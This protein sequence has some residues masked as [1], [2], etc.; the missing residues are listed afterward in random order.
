MWIGSI[1]Q[2]RPGCVL[3]MGS[4]VPNGEPVIHCQAQ[5]Q[6]PNHDLCSSTPLSG[7]EQHRPTRWSRTAKVTPS[8]SYRVAIVLSLAAAVITGCEG[9]TYRPV[10][11][12]HQELELNEL[13][14]VPIEHRVIA[15]AD[16]SEDTG[17]L[18]WT[19]S[20]VYL[21]RAGTHPG[22][23]LCQG[24]L[25]GVAAA[26][27][28]PGTSLVEIVDSTRQALF[29]IRDDGSCV[30]QHMRH[31]GRRIAGAAQ[32]D[33]SWTILLASRDQPVQLE[34]LRFGGRPVL[35]V[36]FDALF[37]RAYNVSHLVLARG[38]GGI[39]LSSAQWPFGWMR[40][41]SA[42]ARRA[43]ATGALSFGTQAYAE[44]FRSWDALPA[45]ALDRAVA[46]TLVDPAS[47]RRLLVVYDTLGRFMSMTQ[48]GSSIEVRAAARH[49]SLLVATRSGIGLELVVY[50]WKWTP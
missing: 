27:F 32:S 10:V 17:L 44:T 40:L 41:D 42:G 49:A 5:R 18:Y 19:L 38:R 12:R 7:Q 25:E 29:H 33:G 2:L 46:Q 16:V 11:P 4:L 23:A 8:Q 9:P 35:A 6:D 20:A 36:T 24:R 1:P 39:L 13:L 26:S 45:V 21:V 14:T 28:V 31:E 34:R 47:E 22:R 50:A 48:P 37:D 30:A 15:G 3:G 43:H